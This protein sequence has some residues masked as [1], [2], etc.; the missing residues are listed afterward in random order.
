M[1]LEVLQTTFKE[2]VRSAMMSEQKKKKTTALRLLPTL[3]SNFV[4]GLTRQYFAKQQNPVDFDIPTA[5]GS[6]TRLLE[7]EL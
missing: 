6:G 1:W 2:E 3:L 5:A 4:A 7:V